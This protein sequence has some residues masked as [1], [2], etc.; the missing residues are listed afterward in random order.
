MNKRKKEGEKRSF[1]ATHDGRAI[2]KD[3]AIIC[4]IIIFQVMMQI[5]QGNR[6]IR[7]KETVNRY[8]C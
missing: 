5:E 8:Y 2:V 6:E 3:V 1:A 7:K 4:E